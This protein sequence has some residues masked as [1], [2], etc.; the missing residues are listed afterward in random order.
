VASRFE[1]RSRLRRDARSPAPRSALDQIRQKYQQETRLR[2]APAAPRTR[3]G[4]L[5]HRRS[6]EALDTTEQKM[7]EHELAIARDLQANILPR[8]LP[9]IPGYDISAY[10]KSSREVGGDYYDFIEVDERHLG[11][12]VADVSGKGIPGSMVV[13]EARVLLRTL[14]PGCL[15]PRQVLA[16]VNHQLYQD[17]IRG[18]FVT[19]YYAILD[20]PT[21]RLALS[22]AGHNPMVCYRAARK[23]CTL[24]NPRGM[25]LGFDPG[26]LFER[27]SEERQLALEPGDR[28]LLY[29]DGV[30]ETFNGAREAYG[31]QR[32]YG[33]VRDHPHE[34]SQELIK[35]LAADL[36]RFQGEAPQH[37][38]ITMVALRILPDGPAAE[39]PEPQSKSS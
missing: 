35:A 15:S 14:A 39:P 3:L 26:P 36:E 16:R 32:L 1:R 10:Y 22:S 11:L 20:V 17:I 25:A 18:M 12:V 30:V 19:V 4:L 27:T 21:R 31:T 8:R 38:D 33:F 2:R 28:L 9:Q 23:S 34:R 24:V 6:D 37:D 29:T 13:Q 5:K 7:M